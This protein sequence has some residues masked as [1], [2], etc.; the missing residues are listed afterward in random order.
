MSLEVRES[1]DKGFQP[2]LPGCTNEA[3]FYLDFWQLGG[4]GLPAPVMDAS[5]KAAVWVGWH[6]GDTVREV[7]VLA[8]AMERAKRIQ[9]GYT[10]DYYI[11]ALEVEAVRQVRMQATLEVARLAVSSA[12]HFAG[13][14]VYEA[15][16]L[17]QSFVPIIWSERM[18]AAV[19][20]SARREL[21]A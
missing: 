11:G 17:L 8:I 21:T 15:V 16:E 9:S 18:D 19:M 10:G 12:N 2:I 6:P 7:P 20:I 4:R 14:S 13:S 3:A 5:R 1:I